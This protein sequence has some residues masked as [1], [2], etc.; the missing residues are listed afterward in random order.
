[1]TPAGW[2]RATQRSFATAGGAG[3]PEVVDQ[4]DMFYIASEAGRCRVPVSLRSCALKEGAPCGKRARRLSGSFDPVVMV[5]PGDEGK[6]TE[7]WMTWR[8]RNR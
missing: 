8:L 2:P 3:D 1:M 6:R 5:C 4:S 7:G